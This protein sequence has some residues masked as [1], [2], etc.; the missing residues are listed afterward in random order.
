[1]AIQFKCPACGRALR[2]GDEVAGKQVRCPA[3][4]QVMQVPTK[5]PVA[6]QSEWPERVE[7]AGSKPAQPGPAVRASTPSTVPGV[8]TAV[9]ERTQRRSMRRIWIAGGAVAAVVLVLF[10]AVAFLRGPSIRYD[11][12]SDGLLKI[13]AHDP[14]V[15]SALG[16]PLRYQTRKPSDFPAIHGKEGEDMPGDILLKATTSLVDPDDD[17]DKVIMNFPVF[18]AGPRGNAVAALELHGD[19]TKGRIVK[20]TV[21]LPDKGIVAVIGRVDKTNHELDMRCGVKFEGGD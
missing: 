18:I 9:G 15:S 1:M 8:L 16:T 13:L 10:V 4:R 11:E 20:L 2:V 21:A 14:N 5:G 7:P 12:L 17:A 3:C 19:L 6:Q